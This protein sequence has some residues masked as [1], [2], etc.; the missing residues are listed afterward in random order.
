[1]HTD[2]IAGLKLVAS[3]AQHNSVYKFPKIYIGH[4]I[5][6][7]WCKRAFNIYLFECLPSNLFEIY[8][9]NCLFPAQAAAITSTTTTTSPLITGRVTPTK[10][11]ESSTTTNSGYCMYK[12]RKYAV[13]E[14]IEDGCEKICKCLNGNDTI[15]C[16]PRC[17]KMN[18]TTSEQCVTVADPK[19]AC[20]QLE[21]CD[22]TLDD[23]EQ[24]SGAIVVVPPPTAMMDTINNS[25]K[26]M[27]V[28][29][30]EKI[31]NAGDI[32]EGPHHCVHKEKKYKKGMRKIKQ[33]TKVIFL[34]I[35]LLP[36]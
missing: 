16:E 15:E 36:F 34:M 10:G 8:L 25:T 19:D 3:N 27:Q 11:E 2:Y 17:P 7:A 30:N 6:V 21:L 13:N 1:M 35:F 20:C 5:T 26:S 33:R 29:R 18:H 28:D 12:G 32:D 23:H 9:E 14:R 22:V 31:K 24:T 4:Y